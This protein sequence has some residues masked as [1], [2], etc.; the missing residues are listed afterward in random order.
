MSFL[1][2]GTCSWKYD[3]WTGIFYSKDAHSNYLAQYVQKLDTVE[4]DQWFWSLHQGG[5]I[6]LPRPDQARAYA[7]SVPANFRFTIKVPNSITL[8]HFYAKSE[9]GDLVLNP[10][11][12]SAELFR[13]FVI[14]LQPLHPYIGAFI[15]QFEYL[16]K[17]KM[18]SQKLWLDLL[19][20]FFSEIPRDFVYAIETRNPAYLNPEFFNFMNQ[21]RLYPVFL[22]GY[23]MPSIFSYYF[24]FSELLSD[25]AII[26]LHGPDRKDMEEK[27]Q[28]VWNQIISP[29]D[30]ELDELIEMLQQLLSRKISIYLNVNNHYEGSAPLTI[31]RIKARLD[32]K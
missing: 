30:R 9:T 32:M 11:F 23:Y 20:L 26:R 12:L 15:F 27:S 2:I 21:H 5:K 1:R 4:I 31:E 3:S 29:K 8:T 16:N 10:N 18:A 19:K 7:E 13:Q 6:I 24:K 22:Q 28:N 14:A 25:L 17:Q